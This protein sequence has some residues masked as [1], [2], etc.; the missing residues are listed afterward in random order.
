M[1][2]AALQR[3]NRIVPYGLGQHDSLE[4]TVLPSAISCPP[5]MAPLLTVTTVK[6]DIIS[7][8][9]VFVLYTLLKNMHGS[10]NPFV[11]VAAHKYKMA[12]GHAVMWEGSPDP[13][14]FSGPLGWKFAALSGRPPSNLQ[15]SALFSVHVFPFS[16][17]PNEA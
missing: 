10:N 16:L 12:S 6:L 13:L 17:K 14:F 8:I 7:V 5:T 1:P 11:A 4:V 9:L 2:N 15:P 3:L